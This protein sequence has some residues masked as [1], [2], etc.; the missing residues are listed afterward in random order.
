MTKG[1]SPKNIRFTASDGWE[2]EADIYSSPEPK[3]AI[4]ISAG[5][6]FPRQFYQN[7]AAYLAERGAIVLTYDYRG[8][9][10]SAG[11]DL[12][13]S[14]IE[15]SDWGRFDATAALDAL[16]ATAPGLPL[17][18]LCHSV[19]G[20]FIGLMPNQSNIS[21]H[22]FVSVGTGFFGGHH[23]R[24]IPSE[25]YFWWGL[26]TYS[27][28]RYGYIKAVGGWQGEPLPPKL[29]K[30]WRRWSHRR[31]YFQS[32]LAATLAPQHYDEV[33]API[34]SW[35]FPDDPIA[36]RK[37]SADLLKCYPFAPHEVIMRKPSEVGVARIGHEGALRKG[38]EV[39]WAEFWDWLA[40]DPKTIKSTSKA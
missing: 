36:T 7:V 15:Y 30:T 22:A 34:R 2:L 19:G 6:G 37:T 23:L 14:G 28:L 16:Q 25:L 26:G 18:H 33:K 13:S 24:N 12:A 10:G 40:A 29:F 3:I 8:I 11:S 35:I 21:R 20:H 1:I 5:T 32:D 38:R 17:T 27:L 31:S 4:L 39:L 9:G